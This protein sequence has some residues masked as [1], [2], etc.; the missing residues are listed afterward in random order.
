M[1]GMRILL[2]IFS[3]KIDISENYDTIGS[4]LKIPSSDALGGLN[5]ELR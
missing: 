5:Y 4:Q 2:L 1:A 3:A